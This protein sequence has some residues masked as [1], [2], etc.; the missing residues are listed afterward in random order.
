[1]DIKR[2]DWVRHRPTGR[3]GRVEAIGDGLASIASW[4]NEGDGWVTGL[5]ADFEPAAAGAGRQPA[6][7]QAA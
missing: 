4:P 1:M 5:A 2:G 6:R 3:V 7:P